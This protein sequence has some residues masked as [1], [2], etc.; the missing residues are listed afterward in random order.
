MANNELEARMTSSSCPEHP[1]MRSMSAILGLEELHRALAQEVDTQGRLL[2]EVKARKREEAEVRT[3][4]AAFLRARVAWAC[5]ERMAQDAELDRMDREEEAEMRGDGRDKVILTEEERAA[6]RLCELFARVELEDHLRLAGAKE[7][8]TLMG[9][10][11]GIKEV[12]PLSEED[13]DRACRM[14]EEAL[15]DQAAGLARMMTTLTSGVGGGGGGDADLNGKLDGAGSR[16]AAAA[17]LPE[18]VRAE[19]DAVEDA[20]K[21]EEEAK[22]AMDGDWQ[23]PERLGRGLDVLESLACDHV[24]GRRA[25]EEEA[26]SHYLGVKSKT[27]LLKIK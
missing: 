17:R 8:A 23:Y 4:R 3:A 21:E 10:E 24:M 26:Q 2:A 6:D 11:H 7:E 27:L 1:L 5:V 25:A 14:M 16:Y 12:K 13:R 19:A 20:E 15:L 22:G 18:M 9:L